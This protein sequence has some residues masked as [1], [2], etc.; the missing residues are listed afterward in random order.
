MRKQI[1]FI[2]AWLIPFLGTWAQELSLEDCRKMAHDNYPAI[3]Q[4]RLIE[5]SRKYNMENISRNWLPQVSLSAGGYAYTDVLKENAQLEMMGIDLKNQ[6]ANASVIIRQNIYDGGQTAAGRHIA[7]AQSDVQLQ[8]LEVSL[9][10]VNERVDQLYFGILLIDEQLNQNTLLKADLATSGKTIASMRKNG[11]AQQDDEDA[12]RVEQLK[13]EQ[14]TDALQ[15]SKK[16][17]LRML[18]LFIGKTLDESIQLQKPT[19]ASVGNSVPS[20]PELNYYASQN[21]LIEAQRKQ[22]NSKLRPT[23]S[24]FGTG[25]LHTQ[26]SPLLNNGLLMGG[27]SVS[28]N[29]GALYTRRNDLRNL[30]LQKQMNESQQE[31]FL[32]NN[33][34]QSEETNGTIASLRKQ[35]TQDDEIVRLREHIRSRSDKKVA[36]GTESVNDMIRHIHAVNIARSE[37]ALHEIQLLQAIFRLKYIQNN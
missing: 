14:Q 2:A 31:V 8:Q 6:V 4:Y 20:R 17:Y 27:V 33:S 1:L 24:L 5:N 34:L 18:G 36:A 30:D 29:I 16:A 15:A 21:K 7:S 9:Y 37:R 19:S 13:A 32:F 26:V 10:N 25:T 12:I 11:M 35:I 28:W 23:V 22:L 3:K